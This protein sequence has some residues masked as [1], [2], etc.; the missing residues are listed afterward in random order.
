MEQLITLFASQ[1]FI[2]LNKSLDK[3]MLGEKI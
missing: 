1:I 2:L 3:T